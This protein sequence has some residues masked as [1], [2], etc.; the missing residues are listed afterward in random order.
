MNQPNTLPEKFE[1]RLRELYSKKELEMVMQSFVEDPSPSFRVNTIKAKTAEAVAALQAKGYELETVPWN[2][3]AFIMKNKSI[4]ELTETEV[5]KNGFIYIQN[6]SSMIPALVLDP[7][8]NDYILDIA[9]APGSKTTQIAALMQNTGNIVANDVSPKRLYKLKDNL[10]QTG[11]T[12]V[13]VVG[14]RGESFWQRYP[15]L[16][17]KV[18]IDVPCSMEG[19]MRLNEPKTYQDW[20]P[21]KVKQLS[22]LQK[23]MLRSAI[24]ATKVGGTIVYSSCTLS[25]EE[26]E[27]VIEWVVSK[28]PEAL[29]VEKITLPELSL[30]P[31]L[32]KWKKKEFA[33]TKNTAR[34]MPSTTM[35]G[36]FIAKIKKHASTL[37][38]LKKLN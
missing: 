12:N 17:D 11:V 18:L 27:E 8:E 23:Y 3:D 7:Q 25:P 6:L 33:Y 5:Y 14:L 16:F 4:R 1:E 21:K 30:Q 20:S 32:T 38:K 13:R 31:G 35:E 28:T 15:E 2:K 19:R 24:S 22:K 10:R 29:E 26:N 37:P 9:A 34:V 36:F